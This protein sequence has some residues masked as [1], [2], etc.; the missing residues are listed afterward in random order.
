MSV[1]DK[2]LYRLMRKGE[3]PYLTLTGKTVGA[4]S[5][6]LKNDSGKILLASGT[7]V[8]SVGSAL[9]AKGAL[10]IDTDVADGSSAIYENTGTVTSCSFVLTGGI[11]AS[12][13][14]SLSTLIATADSKA[15]SNSVV[16]ST[17]LV[18]GTSRATSNSVVASTNL[19]ADISRA[20]SLSVIASS[21][22]VTGDSKAASNSVLISTG[23][24]T[25]STN[26]S[27]AK[28]SI[29]TQIS[30]AISTHVAG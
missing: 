16:E 14:A 24:V 10:F 25:E 15:V 2:F 17:N 28:A 19:A 13:A 7:S 30:V 20:T 11:N 1:L 21:N 26:N 3:L 9:Y 29:A 4:V 18:A 12:M 6:L 8:P 22:L 5:V 23:V 27:S